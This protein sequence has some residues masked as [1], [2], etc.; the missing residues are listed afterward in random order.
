M[1]ARRDNGK[2]GEILA[3]AHRRAPVFYLKLRSS[4]L[5]YFQALDRQDRVLRVV[6]RIE[7]PRQRC[8]VGQPAYQRRAILM[9]IFRSRNVHSHQACRPIER[10]T[11]LDSNAVDGRA[12]HACLAC[13]HNHLRNQHQASAIKQFHL[14]ADPTLAHRC[15]LLDSRNCNRVRQ[16]YTVNVAVIA[17]FGMRPKGALRGVFIES[18]PCVAQAERFS[19]P[20]PSALATASRRPCTPSFW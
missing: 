20:R 14:Q 6:K 5:A 16:V 10:Y 1:T 11:P 18:G 19:M 7:Q 2:N 9:A 3:T 17:G 13:I 8:L 4:R 12:A 15:T